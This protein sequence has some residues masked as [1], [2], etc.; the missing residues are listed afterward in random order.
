MEYMNDGRFAEDADG[1]EIIA[2]EKTDFF[3]DKMN[4]MEKSSAPFAFRE[5]KGDF[6]ASACVEPEFTEDYDAGGIFILE[7]DARWIKL[8]FEKTDLGYPSVVSV[9]TDGASDDA[10]GEKMEGVGKV[11]LQVVRRN[12]YWALHYSL[13]GKAWKMVRYFR[14]KMSETLRIGFVA[15]SPLGKGTRVK[16][17]D[18]HIGQREIGNLRRGK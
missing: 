4:G 3:I 7:N 10:N 13:D 18:I 5:M 9:I 15:Q 12:D 8:E 14:L 1:I 11:F 17:S 2:A 16:F 6:V